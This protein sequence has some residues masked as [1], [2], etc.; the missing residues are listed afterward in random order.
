MSKTQFLDINKTQS[1]VQEYQ[2]NKTTQL[3]G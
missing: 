2:Q 3:Q 1:M